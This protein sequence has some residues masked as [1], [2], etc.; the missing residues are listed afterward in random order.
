[1][2]PDERRSLW[3]AVA[4]VA[5]FA[6]APVALIWPSPDRVR[7]VGRPHGHRGDRHGK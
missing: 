5:C 3:L 6:T 4:A 2:K 1:M 7:E